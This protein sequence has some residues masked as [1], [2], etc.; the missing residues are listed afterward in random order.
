MSKFIREVFFPWS[1]FRVT[2]QRLGNISDNIKTTFRILRRAKEPVQAANSL[3]QAELKVRYRNA[4]I[5]ALGLLALLA[6]SVY[7]LMTSKN[8]QSFVL[9]ALWSSGVAVYYLALCK[10]LYKSR[11]ALSNWNE[12]ENISVTLLDY[13]NAVAENPKNLL[14]CNINN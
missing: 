1:G 8:L 9:S 7:I 13:L 10:D 4:R 5:T 12:R 14:P 3:K 2:K 11:V 6:W